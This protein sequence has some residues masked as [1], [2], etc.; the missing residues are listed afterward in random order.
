MRCIQSAAQGF[1]QIVE[2]IG[3]LRDFLDSRERMLMRDK[4]T[5]WEEIRMPRVERVKPYARWNTSMLIGEQVALQTDNDRNNIKSLKHVVPDKNAKFHS[6][7]FLK[8]AHDFDAIRRRTNICRGRTKRWQD[9]NSNS[10]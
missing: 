10:K 1:S 6:S 4:V 2:D 5:P 9:Y 8:C 3:V 7:A